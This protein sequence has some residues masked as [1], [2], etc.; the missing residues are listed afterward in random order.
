[1]N[2][3]LN[4]SPKDSLYVGVDKDLKYLTDMKHEQ[5]IKLIEAD[6]SKESTLEE[7]KNTI[8]G[9]IDFLFIDGG[10]DKKDV[11]NDFEKYAPLVRKGGIIAFHDIDVSLNMEACDGVKKFW[12]EI[13]LKY[14][15]EEFINTETKVHYGIGII[16]V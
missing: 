13:K 8:N 2:L 9:E 7:V 12:A 15:T 14:D 10:H 5:T 3:W 16:K 4:F 11:R 1:M 6:S